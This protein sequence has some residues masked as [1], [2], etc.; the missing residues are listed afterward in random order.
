MLLEILPADGMDEP[1]YHVK[2][3]KLT[4]PRS[5]WPERNLV[6]PM[7]PI[8]KP[9]ALDLHDATCDR[10]LPSLFATHGAPR[11][12]T[13][14]IPHHTVLNSFGPQKKD[15]FCISR[16][17][18][19][20]PAENT[21]LLTDEPAV[22]SRRVPAKFDQSSA[23]MNESLGLEKEGFAGRQCNRRMRPSE[24]KFGQRHVSR[25]DFPD[26]NT[27]RRPLIAE[28][29]YDHEV[30]VYGYLRRWNSVMLCVLLCCVFF[31]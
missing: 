19:N 3:L 13:Q 24:K 21:S 15:G 7:S 12:S 31:Y 14:K 17:T 27:K 2:K 25:L 29:S 11:V 16:P 5:I 22:F 9:S 8:G 4:G 10:E 30:H 26:R 20:P 28:K 1:P 23:L 18:L 6:L